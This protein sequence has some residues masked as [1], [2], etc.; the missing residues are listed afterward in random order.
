M[1]IIGKSSN[2]PLQV[3]KPYNYDNAA[4]VSSRCCGGTHSHLDIVLDTVRYIAMSN[5]IPRVAPKHPEDMPN[6]PPTTTAVQ[7]K[8]STC[9]FNSDLVAFEIY[10]RASYALKQHLI[11][12]ANGSFGFMATTPLAM[13]QHL[14]T[15][16]G[17]LTPMEHEAHRLDLAKLWNPEPLPSSWLGSCTKRFWLRDTSEWTMSDFR[18][19]VNGGNKESLC[20]LTTGSPM[21]YQG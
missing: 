7:C 11:R 17:T 9:Q 14:D 21:H 12:F 8:Q 3:F 6:H 15:T 16:Y 20:K 18:A 2:C 4:S 19:H 13:L 5:N 10:H 1:K